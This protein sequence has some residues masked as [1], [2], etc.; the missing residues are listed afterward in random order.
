MKLQFCKASRA[1]SDERGM[2]KSTDSLDFW[3]LATHIRVMLN[4][5]NIVASA[6]RSGC[7]AAD[8][9]SAS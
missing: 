5:L 9:I 2:P 8:V 6:R 7:L 1:H 4:V 3:G